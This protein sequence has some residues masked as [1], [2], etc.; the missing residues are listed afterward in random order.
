MEAALPWGGFLFARQIRAAIL[1]QL[2]SG[3]L[4]VH[5]M[6]RHTASGGKAANTLK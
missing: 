6:I 2:R 5:L 1:P 3:T 4:L